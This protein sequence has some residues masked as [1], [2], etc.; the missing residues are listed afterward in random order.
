MLNIA[1]CD[2]EIDYVNSTAD[3]VM[4]IL[5]DYEVDISTYTSGIDLINNS[6][7]RIDILFIDIEMPSLNGIETIRKL[8]VINPSI[9][10]FILTNYT[11]Y[12][13]DVF[14]VG[15]FQFLKSH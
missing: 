1:I 10:V 9:I 11:N 14:R 12:M 6:T 7:K 2:D 4:K 15:T 8:R 3:A 13:T 5:S